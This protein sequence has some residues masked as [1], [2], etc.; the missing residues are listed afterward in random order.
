MR[1]LIGHRYQYVLIVCYSN[2]LQ[3]KGHDGMEQYEIKLKLEFK[4]VQ[5][6]KGYICKGFGS[7]N[8]N[9]DFFLDY[10]FPDY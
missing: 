8:V 3:K 7:I 1:S 2:L 10:V 6:G 4:F 9:V 5:K